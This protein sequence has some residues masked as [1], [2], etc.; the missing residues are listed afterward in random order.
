MLRLTRGLQGKTAPVT[1][2]VGEKVRMSQMQMGGGEGRYFFHNLIHQCKVPILN[3][4]EVN[5]TGVW[6]VGGLLTAGNRKR[7]AVMFPAME[8]EI[9]GGCDG[10]RRT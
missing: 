1:E 3:L 7:V 10:K 4:C 2:S 9:C 6:R 5:P 8:A